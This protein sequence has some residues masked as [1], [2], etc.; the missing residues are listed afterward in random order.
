MV[1][2]FKSLAIS[3]TLVSL[4]FFA[5]VS[6]AFTF[7]DLNNANI[8][9]LDDPAFN[10]SFSGIQSELESV[11]DD[12]Q[13]IRENFEDEVPQ[14][15][16]NFVL[17]TSII[18]SAKLVTTSVVAFYNV[19]TATVSQQLGINPIVLGVLS[20]ILVLILVLLAWRVIKAGE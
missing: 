4:F 20:G 19:L 5:M 15:D 12:N 13:V 2:S 7:G 16:N 17:L 6:F 3:L 10:S 18:S 8:S 9:I 11:Q 14:I 1:K